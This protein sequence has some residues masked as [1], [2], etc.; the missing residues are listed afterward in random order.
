MSS[1]HGVFNDLFKF[2][3][4]LLPK[5]FEISTKMVDPKMNA[6]LKPLPEVW[7]S[8]FLPGLFFPGRKTSFMR[9]FRV[10]RGEGCCYLA[11]GIT[12]T[13]VL[14]LTQR[15]WFFRPLFNNVKCH[16]F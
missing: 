12:M 6:A 4:V 11:T 3:F 1:G 10:L 16:L 5:T 7:N 13:Q 14:F 9:A 2:K 8:L 15:S